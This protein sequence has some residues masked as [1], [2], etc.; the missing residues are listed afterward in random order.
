MLCWSLMRCP[1]PSTDRKNADSPRTVAPPPPLLQI[2]HA[3]PHNW[4]PYL[5]L[6]LRVVFQCT[7]HHFASCR[8]AFEQQMTKVSARRAS[9]FV[10]SV[11]ITGRVH[12]NL[13]A[14]LALPISR[15]FPLGESKPPN[16][17]GICL[18]PC[19]YVTLGCPSNFVVI[20]I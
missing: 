6:L 1:L 13:V 12:L 19:H 18:I 20:A 5:A 17:F 2:S 8:R 11:Q 3:Y 16:M 10:S 15:S 4:A 9:A 14:N 7:R